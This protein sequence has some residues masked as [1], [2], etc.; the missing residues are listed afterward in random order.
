MISAATF[1][2]ELRSR[3]YAFFSG[4]PCSHLSG[5]IEVLERDGDYVPAAN[6]GVALAIAAGAE[7]GGTRSAVLAQNSGLGNLVNPL[8]SLLRPY[9]IPV[10]VVLSLR[11]WP[12]AE[13]DDPQ[14]AVMG[15]ATARILDACEVPYALLDR[16]D[17]DSLARCLDVADRARAERR[18]AFL[19]VPPRSVE[20]ASP[21]THDGAGWTR[22]AALET[23]IPCLG[24]AIVFATTGYTSRELFAV[25][26]RVRT[27]YMQGSMGHVLALALGAAST[28]PDDWIVA[29]D[30]DGAFLMH[31]GTG[32]TVGSAGPPNL[33]HVVIDNGAYES[34][35]GQRTTSGAVCWEELGRGLGY[36]V[37]TVSESAAEFAA[38]IE[39]A[40][41]RPGPHLVVA[42]VEPTNGPM[43]LR[44]SASLPLPELRAR[45]ERA[46]AAPR[47]AVVVAS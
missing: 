5:P 33:T 46:V 32:S 28:R 9:S 40:R 38:A 24:D 19:L 6:E 10:L 7:L 23:L 11:G 14:H 35:G 20:R 3:G 31:L 34:T 29:V 41:A 39:V 21:R 2:S 22:R 45:F 30:G 13:R 12:D 37:T 17:E 27:F 25:G 26:D 42:V 36:A 44:A 43:P 15:R 8:A 1:C 16:A 18:P 47:A 4:V